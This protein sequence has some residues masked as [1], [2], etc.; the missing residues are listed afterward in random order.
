MAKK[1]NEYREEQMKQ[2]YDEYYQRLCFYA[3][4][5]V[6]DHE[7]AKDIVQEIFVKLW[8]KELDFE[9]KYA[10]SAYLYPAVYHFCVNRLHLDEIHK[11][12]HQKIL[13][14]SE[15]SDESHYLN[16]RIED[17]V[18]WDV[19]KAIESL[20]SECQ[21]V[22]RLSYEEGKSIE[23]VA[24]ILN[25]SIHTVKSQRARA[26]KLL[27]EKLKGLYSLVILFFFS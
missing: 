13:Y 17:E 10:L 22:F 18:L 9:N 3:A 27:Q 14:G 2:I 16:D 5:Y 11:Q 8:E 26:K 15:I 25:I 24:Q 1:R 23:E 21:K 4:K 19:F 20:P 6:H 7:E 12:H